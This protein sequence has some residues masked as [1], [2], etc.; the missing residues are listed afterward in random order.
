M[1]ECCLRGQLVQEFQSLFAMFFPT[2]PVIVMQFV[3]IS[4]HNGFIQ[5]VPK[6]SP[7]SNLRMSLERSGR[8][9]ALMGKVS[10]VGCIVPARYQFHRVVNVRLYVVCSYHTT[11]IKRHASYYCSYCRS[12][13]LGVR[14][15]FRLRLEV[16]DGM[17]YVVF[18]MFDRLLV[19]IGALKH[20]C[21]TGTEYALGPEGFKILKDMPILLI[22]RRC[23]GGRELSVP[24]Y[25]VVA[26]TDDV[27]V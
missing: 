5:I 22:V 19:G 12:S 10:G 27:V 6:S 3:K 26:L 14:L 17:Y 11:L 1:F 18:H 20:V 15:G 21:V 9:R 25:Q 4:Q 23:S 24:M 13:V 7:Y 16:F 8:L 2:L